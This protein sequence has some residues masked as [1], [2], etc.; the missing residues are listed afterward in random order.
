CRLRIVAMA[1]FPLLQFDKDV[2]EID[3]KGEGRV[4]QVRSLAL[5]DLGLAT[6]SAGF[7]PDRGDLQIVVNAGLLLDLPVGSGNARPGK[8]IK[9]VPPDNRDAMV[10]EDIQD[11]RVEKGRRFVAS[12]LPR[13]GVAI[14]NWDQQSLSGPMAEPLPDG[15]EFIERTCNPLG[16]LAR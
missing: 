15:R 7:S 3:G 9:Q 13:S 11:R 16:N 14:S 5:V 6:I 4:R 8:R 1:P 10:G 12:M 2:G